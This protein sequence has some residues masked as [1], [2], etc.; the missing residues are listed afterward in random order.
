MKPEILPNP[1]RACLLGLLPLLNSCGSSYEW[2]NCD[3]KPLEAE[4]E[5]LTDECVQLKQGYTAVRNDMRRVSS[6]AKEEIER[7]R[8][9]IVGM[10]MQWEG[11]NDH[12]K[13][14]GAEL[15]RTDAVVKAACQ[16]VDFYRSE[17][18]SEEHITMAVN[19]G[20][21]RITRAVDAFRA[22]EEKE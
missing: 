19:A 8:G 1:V 20:W 22:L 6:A 12:R 2:C 11:C 17:P 10:E 5:R 18:S 7:L 16:A 9:K 15:D 3:I 4:I 14:L 13:T 21:F